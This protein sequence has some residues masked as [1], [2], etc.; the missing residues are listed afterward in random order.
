MII[1]NH[2]WLRLPLGGFVCTLCGRRRDEHAPYR[3]GDCLASYLL[4]GIHP[5]LVAY[6]DGLLRER[7]PST[8][9][10]E[11]PASA[12]PAASGAV[13]PLPVHGSLVILSWCP[14]EAVA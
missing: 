6:R 11:T 14:G 8:K 1:G 4:A 2:S 5:D 7:R 3:G 12:A 13:L 9:D 10:A